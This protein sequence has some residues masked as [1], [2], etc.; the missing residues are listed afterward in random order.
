[1]VT[2][3]F[4]HFFKKINYGYWGFSSVVECFLSK[5]KAPSFRKQT[6]KQ[7]DCVYL[8]CVNYNTQVKVIGQLAGQISLLS[9]GSWGLNSGHLTWQ[10]APLP[11]EH[12]A[13][14]RNVLPKS[15]YY[16]EWFIVTVGLLS[17][18]HILCLHKMKH[19]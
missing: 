10:Q 1:M 18:G 7:T 4:I 11:M 13:N 16:S 6:S 3:K 15:H 17:L 14:L 12:L 5:H 19:L 9:C 2:E 8:G